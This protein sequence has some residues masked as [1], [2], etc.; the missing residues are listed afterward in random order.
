MEQENIE[1]KQEP[2]QEIATISAEDLSADAGA[3]LENVTPEDLIIPQLKLV[4][5]NSPMVDPNEGGYIQ[6]VKVG[7]IVNNVTGEHYDG[8]KG[9]T[10]VPVAYRRVFLEFQDR[11]VGGGL[12]QIHSNPN[13]LMN[14]T[15]R[16]GKDT[17]EGGNYIQTTA[18]HYIIQL[19]GDKATPLMVAMASTQLKKSRRWNS[20]MA[21]IR[22]NDSKGET[23]TPASY[24][25]TYQLCS[26]PEKNSKGSWYGWKIDLVGRVGE[27]SVYNQA[28]TFAQSITTEVETVVE[29][30]VLVEAF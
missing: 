1:L 7:D 3:G 21:G 10:V 27:V 28:K 4:Q 24:S 18:N 9:I 8:E 19:E 26:T 11:D 25:H 15:L 12:V 20:I 23:F 17:L 16:N 30:E 5:K 14:T 13:V 2:K 22:M 6:G 29:K